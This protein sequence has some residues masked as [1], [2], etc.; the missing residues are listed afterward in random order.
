MNCEK[1]KNPQDNFQEEFQ[2]KIQTEFQNNDFSIQKKLT[3]LTALC[4]FLSAVEFAL[5][6]P[7]PF[8]RI[9][10]ANLPI[11][12][13]FFLLPTRFSFL[14]ILLKIFVQNLIS[15]TLFSYTILFSVA[16]SF[17]SGAVM[18]LLFKIFYKSEDFKNKKISLVGISLAGSLFNCAGQL[19]V[20]YI[21]IFGENT[22]Y[23]APVLLGTSFVTGLL[24][25]V[26]SQ[27][28]VKKSAWL[29]M[30]ILQK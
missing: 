16:G 2:K 13:S 17:A 10:L 3:L 6:K 24:L 4:L 29:K 22:K 9:G 26:F 23:I 30:M 28:F 18:I 15:G 12:L 5:P 8:F 1:N 20:S 7:F 14:L 21:L 25:G 27:M 11:I 19:G